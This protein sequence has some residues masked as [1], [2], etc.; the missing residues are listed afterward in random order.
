MPNS[1]LAVYTLKIS[2]KSTL[3]CAYRLIINYKF[4]N[5]VYNWGDCTEILHLESSFKRELENA[6]CLIAHQ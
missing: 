6:P 1:L 3:F 5:Y 4:G 2:G